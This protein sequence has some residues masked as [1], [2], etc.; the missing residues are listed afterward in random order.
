METGRLDQ[1]PLTNSSQDILES[2]QPQAFLAVLPKYP[3]KTAKGPSSVAC[4]ETDHAALLPF[5]KVPPRLQT[6]HQI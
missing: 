6:L 3:A 4:W 1:I 5:A 2:H